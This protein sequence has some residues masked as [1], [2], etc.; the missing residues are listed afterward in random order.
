VQLELQLDTSIHWL[1]IAMEHLLEAS[2][3]HKNLLSSKANESINSSELDQEFKSCV[4]ATVAAAT[5]FEAL[6]TAV[7]ERLPSKPMVK[8]SNRNQRPARYAIVTEALRQ[9]FGLKKQGTS[10]LRA[11]LKEIYRFRDEAVHPSSKFSA[12]VHR[13]EFGV[14]VERRFVMFSYG[15]ARQIVRAALAFSKMLTSRDLSR[16]PKDIQAFSSY[17]ANVCDPLCQQWEHSFG[18][19]FE[20]LQDAA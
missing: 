19:L 7:L 3:L 13:A 1:E 14:W 15:N 18:P 5:F 17:L 4:Q 9:A 10:N 11:V 16:R 20:Q 8:G 6:Y 12:P 2:R